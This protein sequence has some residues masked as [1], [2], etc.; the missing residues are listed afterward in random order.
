MS[1]NDVENGSWCICGGV[2]L[3]ALNKYEYAITIKKKRVPCELWH[4][5]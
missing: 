3:Q 4:I 2:T 5:T 1:I